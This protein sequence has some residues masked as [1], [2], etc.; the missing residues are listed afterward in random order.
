MMII[1][2]MQLFFGTYENCAM[3]SSDDKNKIK[4]GQP[5]YSVSAVT[6]RKRVLVAHGQ[7]LQVSDH[8]FNKLPLVPTFVLSHDIPNTVNETFYHG[9]PYVYLKTHATEP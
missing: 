9:N 7:S 4:V 1:T 3:I 6:R 5:N 8:D 2:I